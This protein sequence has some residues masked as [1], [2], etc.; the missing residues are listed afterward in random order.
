M[1]DAE[2]KKILETLL[3][4]TDA[5]LPVSRIAQ[6]CEIKNKE[7]L[8]G[9]LQELRKSYDD[10]GRTLQVMQVA[11][12]WQ[13]AT[14]PEYG[15]WVRKLYNNK[16]TVRLTQ[17]ALETLCIIA[18]K[19]PLTRAEVEAIRGVEVIGPLETL[20]QRK[21]I[22][23]VG[24]RESIGRPILYGT[25]SEFLRQFGLNSLD[26][27]PKL[28]TFNIEN[29]SLGA[30]STAVEL[31]DEETAVEP[32]AEGEPPA[33]PVQAAAELS[34]DVPPAEPAGEPAAEEVQAAPEAAQ[35]EPA[36]ETAEP[37]AEPVE[38]AQAEEPAAEAAEAAP[39]EE[40][41][42]AAAVE[43]A[44]ESAPEEPRDNN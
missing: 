22:T 10:E 12:G 20:S 16:M 14:R 15:I 8:E 7:R 36:G 30:Q 24:R 31:V 29:A 34:Q 44:A 38:S 43:Q 41:V 19:Q 35:E 3:F 42:E 5:P 39:A 33:D 40:P 2:L 23:V 4:I 26:A 27:L 11:G 9:A 21:L 17:A 6:L 1:E 37:A 28:E 25:T 13:L 18:Y 32:I